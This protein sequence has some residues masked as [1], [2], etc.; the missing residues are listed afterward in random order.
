MDWPLIPIFLFAALAASFAN[1]ATY[2]WAWNHRRVS[3]WQ[4]APEGVTPR[5]WLDRIPIIGWL[6]LRRDEKVLGRGYWIRPMAVELLFAIS[7]A[8]L[9]WFECREFGLIQPQ[10]NRALADPT[11]LFWP[12]FYAFILH[13]ALSV[14]MV[15]ATLIDIDEKTIPDEITVPG[16]LLGLVLATFLPIGLLPNIEERQPLA[17]PAV[18]Q[19]LINQQL[20]RPIMGRNGSTV[21]IEPTHLASPN[22]WPEM[23]SGGTREGLLVGLGCYWLWCFALTTRIWRGRRGL[24]FALTILLRRVMRDLLTTPLREI[25]IGGTLAIL[26]V[27]VGLLSA[28]VGMAVAGGIVWAVRLIGS[29]ALGKEAMGFGDVTLMMMIGAFLGWQASVLTFFL[30]PFA[31]LVI[32]VAQFLFKRDDVIPYGPFLCLGAAAVVLRWGMLWPS[33]EPFCALGAFL[34]AVLIVCLLLLG[35]MLWIWAIFKARMLNVGEN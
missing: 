25:F 8:A 33:I 16:M 11:G 19:E 10:S 9:F 7:M 22:D 1:A 2:A 15:I 3:P 20:E 35:A 5:G 27:W 6:R 18:G 34:P 13:A 14:L 17:A 28:L 23:L 31:A 26:C 30:A 29:A 32:G 21:W 24:G 4:L 12:A